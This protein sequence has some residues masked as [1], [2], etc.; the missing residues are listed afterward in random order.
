MEVSKEFM[1]DKVKR[2][3]E[4]MKNME[5]IQDSMLDIMADIHCECLKDKIEEITK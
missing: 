2:I 5:Q 1:I 3:N 4:L